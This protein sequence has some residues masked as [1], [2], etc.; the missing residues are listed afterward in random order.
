[1][2]IFECV[3]HVSRFVDSYFASTPFDYKMASAED[4]DDFFE[5]EAGQDD[6]DD[7]DDD[8]DMLENEFEVD[9][10]EDLMDEIVSPSKLR[11]KCLAEKDVW[12]LVDHEVMHLV[13]ITSLPSPVACQILVSLNWDTEKAISKIIDDQ[14]ALFSKVTSCFFLYL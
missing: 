7:D 11:M 6:D 2:I 3:H 14:E 8:D 13:D 1:M 4:E 12:G 5:C 10:E 9:F